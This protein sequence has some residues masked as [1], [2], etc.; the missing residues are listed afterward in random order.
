M[1]PL[2]QTRVFSERYELTH[3]IARGGMAQVY[4]AHDRLLDRVVALKVL[5][6]ELSVDQTFVER[7]R[8]EALAAA[9]LSHPNIVPVF[10]WGEDAGTYFIVMEFVAGEP[11]SATLRQHG[12]LPAARA[13]VIAAEVAAALSYAHR[14]GVVHR[15]VKPGNVLI[16]EDGSVKVTDFGIARALNTEESLTQAGSVMGTA[17]YF[18]PEQAEGAAVDARSDVYS[19][20]IVLYEM[21]AGRPPF[22]GDSPVA[23]ASKHVREMPPLIRQ[24]QI[25]VPEPVE[26]IAMM[27][28]AKSPIDRY[29]S[30][31]AMR[32]DLMRFV[33]GLPVEAPD[34]LIAANADL[35]N[36]TTMMGAVN[37]TQAVPIFPGP[38]TDLPRSRR[39]RRRRRAWTIGTLSLVLVLLLGLAA[40]GIAS[41]SSSKTTLSVPNVVGM[42]QAK[43]RSALKKEGLKVG[44]VS[45]IGSNKPVDQV[46]STNPGVG[47]PISKGG[48]VDL[49][50]SN[51]KAAIDVVVPDVSNQLLPAAESTLQSAGF[52]VK[53]VTSN[54]SS[55]PINTVIGQSPAG[56]SKA[57]KGSLV[58]LTI[59]P[60]PSTVAVPNVVGQTA[61]SAAAVIGSAQLTVGTQD[62]KC[63]NAQPNGS[64][65]SQDPPAGATVAPNVA[66]N[67]VIS[68]GPCSV[69]V[70]NVVGLQYSVAQGSLTNA[71]LNSSSSSCSSG[72]AVVSSQSP[73]YP[74]T[75]A[76]GAT[77][78][79]TCS[80]PPT[81]TTTSATTTTG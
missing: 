22:Q 60:P 76:S 27:A 65:S 24:F 13:A 57:P 62:S 53:V 69:S 38:R 2:E 42:S 39:S 8:R 49:T 50:V 10:D 30:A 6:P 41:K 77:V 59:V 5:F 40:W 70:P 44:I 61:S 28:I 11:L 67:L 52:T 46:I 80:S 14:H 47:L 21:L 1:E 55:A 58:T 45:Q 48:S 16:T 25:E 32:S 18:S 29:P 17:T 33:E 51:G 56:G 23:V 19:L 20:G 37:T 73:S 81:T 34:P 68:T 54:N 43:A 74:T 64:V 35:V 78:T 72:S 26:A 79:L 4:R 75:V 36:A 71:G 66:V 3:L 12:T 15:D 31:E 9:K 7:F 63:D